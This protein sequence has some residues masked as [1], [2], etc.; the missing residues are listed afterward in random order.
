MSSSAERLS[1]ESSEH[2]TNSISVAII[3][4]GEKIMYNV[5]VEPIERRDERKKGEGR[6]DAADA[7]HEQ[8]RLHS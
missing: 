1:S 2:T 6:S 8:A 7:N 5:W 3:G 4:G